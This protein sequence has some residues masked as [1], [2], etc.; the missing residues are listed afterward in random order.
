M[1]DGY[2]GSLKGAG[3][4]TVAGEGWL[5]YNY[6]YYY[7]YYYCFEVIKLILI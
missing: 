7:Y 2:V 3:A 5:T 1:H 6:Y 4:Q